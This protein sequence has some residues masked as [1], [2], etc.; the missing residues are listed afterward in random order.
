[1]VRGFEFSRFRGNRF[2]D[3]MGLEPL[4]LRTDLNIENNR[5][6]DFSAGY[7]GIYLNYSHSAS[8]Y[9]QMVKISG[10]S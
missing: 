3:K 1:M 9:D 5:L 8:N 6:S 4:Y 2:L 7:L 10:T